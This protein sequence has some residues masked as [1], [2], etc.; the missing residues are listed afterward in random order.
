MFKE[1]KSDMAEEGDISHLS[2]PLIHQKQSHL[3]RKSS[4]CYEL[5]FEMW[6]KCSYEYD[7]WDTYVEGLHIDLIHV[8]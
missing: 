6:H 2:E 7:E 8:N 1:L 5:M 3:I 4:R